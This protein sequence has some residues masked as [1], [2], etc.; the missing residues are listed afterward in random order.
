M[1][2]AERARLQTEAGQEV[3]IQLV[4]EALVIGRVN[5][6]TADGT[7]QLQ[8][9]LYKRLIQDGREVWNSAGTVQTRSTGEFRFAE[10][11]AGTYKVFTH[12]EIDRDLLTFNPRGQLY[13]YPASLLSV[14]E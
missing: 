4:P 12:E 6:P 13:G 1:K 10:I 7:D 3:T 14:V 8:V 2:I 9:E 5:L 11:A